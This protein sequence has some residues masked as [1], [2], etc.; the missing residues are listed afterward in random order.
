MTLHPYTRTRDG[1]APQLGL[2]LRKG[3]RLPN[4]DRQKGD[5]MSEMIGFIGLGNM[6]QAMANSL[7]KAGYTLTVYNRTLS[8]A[9]ALTAKGA[10]LAH[11]PGEPVTKGA[12]LISMEPNNQP[13]YKFPMN[14]AFLNP[15]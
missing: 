3:P 7:L 15:L 10:R 13:L 1:E 11:Q 8:K 2:C 5:S 12:I 6:G 9:E 4:N 14:N